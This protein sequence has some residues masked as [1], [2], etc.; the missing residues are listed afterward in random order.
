MHTSMLVLLAQAR[1]PICCE[2]A[3]YGSH[4][5]VL[6]LRPKK[7]NETK[8]SK[9]RRAVIIDENSPSK[10]TTKD[11]E[12]NRNVTDIEDNG[13]MT[14]VALTIA[15][16]VIDVATLSV[17]ETK[18]CARKIQWITH[19]EFTAEKGRRQIQELISVS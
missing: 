14:A 17:G 4:R 9:G 2:E 10:V 3:G 11:T 13:T 12:D 16:D 1:K 6:L 5:L 19:G 15:E 8:M 7:I 18:H